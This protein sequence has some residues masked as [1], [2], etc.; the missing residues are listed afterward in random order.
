MAADRFAGKTVIVTGAGSG[1]GKATAVRIA[2]EGGKVVAADVVAPRLEEL[3]AENPSLDI[4]TVAGDI[5]KDEDIARIVDAAGGQVWGLAN[6]AGVMDSFQPAHEIDWKQWDF[7]LAVNLTATAKL[8]AAVIPGM[9][10]VGAGSIVNVSSEAGL[11]GSAAGAAYT[12]SKHAVIGLTKNSAVMYGKKGIRVNTVAPGAVQTNIQAEF[13]SQLA[14]EVLGPFMQAV[15]PGM[16]QPEQLAS[17]IAWLLSEDS[18]NVNGAVLA[19]DTGWSA[20]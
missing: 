1:I 17:S 12:A 7:V 10:E 11:R 9:L 2:S 8:M 14:G 5:T 19:N 15:V 20:I 4:V 13:K 16:A 18:A 6:V 3:K